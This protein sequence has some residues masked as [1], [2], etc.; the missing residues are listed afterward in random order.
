VPARAI[1]LGSSLGFGAVVTA[2]VS[3]SVVF[4]F[5]LNT[6][7]A[8]MLIVYLITALAQLRMRRQL[9]RDDPDR[10]TVHMW[11]YPYATQATIVAIIAVLVAMAFTEELASQLYASLLSVAVVLVAYFG[12]RRRSDAGRPASQLQPTGKGELS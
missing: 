6:S 4:A 12:L 11:L 8:V 3:P 7:G 2:V 1:L 10:L 5:L 9:E